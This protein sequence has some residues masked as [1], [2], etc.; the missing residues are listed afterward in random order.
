MLLKSFLLSYLEANIPMA[1]SRISIGFHS[2]P[3][4]SP[5]EVF[6]GFPFL[7]SDLFV[8]Y[9]TQSSSIFASRLSEFPQDLKE[10]VL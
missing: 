5:F 1:F 9:K 3:G 6:Y 7:N 2:T 4:L 10:Y 8:N